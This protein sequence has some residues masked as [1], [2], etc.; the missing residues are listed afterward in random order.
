MHMKRQAALLVAAVAG[1]S[2]G[3]SAQRQP[4]PAPEQG[5]AQP[6]RRKVSL[7]EALQLAAKQ[8]PDVAAAR[9]QAAV[10]HAGVEKAW[11]AWQPDLSASGTFDHT[12]APAEIPAG[13]LTKG[14]DAKA[15]TIIAPNTRLGT[16]QIVQPLLT[17]Q[18]LFAPGI[19]NAAAEAAARGADESREQVLLAVARTY[20]NLQAQEGLLNAAREAERVALRREQDARAQISAGTAVELAL[21]RA[22]TE[23]ASARVQIANFEGNN[24]SLWP[25]LEA[26]TGERV[27]PLPFG[28]PQEI[29]EV[30]ASEAEPWE[31]SYAVKS[32]A[33]AVIAAERSTHLDRF[34]WLPSIS[35]VARGNYNSS[36]GFAGTATSY[37]LILN[38]N[39]PLYDRGQRYAQL[40]EDQARLQE[41]QAQLASA[42]ARAR[43]TWDGAKGNLSSAQVALQQ[44]NIQAELAAKTQQQVDAS[45][46]AG[47][48]TSLDLSDADQRKFLAQSAA[49]QARTEVEVRKAELAVAAG[50]LYRISQQ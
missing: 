47:V 34:A 46:R 11:T 30:P 48:A 41:A 24:Q 12:S 3:A 23:T 36:G 8:G 45:Y 16:L 15:I 43:A 27:E 18:G 37:D 28:A 20:L 33:A 50:A 21:L 7:R 17:P 42:R 6:Q 35:G 32:A 49:A 13:I 5:N 1:I 22:Q 9:A 19:A 39:V 44:A 31:N 40:H 10:V 4:P 14:P 26:L 25:L 29:A 38:V 2:S